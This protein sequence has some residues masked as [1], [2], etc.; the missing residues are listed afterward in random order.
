M[1]GAVLGLLSAVFA[2]VALLLA[3]GV[4][5]ITDRWGE[6]VVILRPLEMPYALRSSTTPEGNLNHWDVTLEP[7]LSVRRR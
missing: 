3:L 5:R 7:E 1:S 2:L 6:R 4:G